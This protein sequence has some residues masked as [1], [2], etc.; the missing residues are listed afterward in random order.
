MTI[1]NNKATGF[2]NVPAEAWEVLS[3]K[4]DEIGILTGLFN[5]IKNKKRFSSE[6]KATIIC[7]IYKVMVCTDE[8]GDY[9]GI[10]LLSV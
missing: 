2:G 7:L 4:N 10:S 9:R 1:K 3:T 5:Q 6:W 8:P